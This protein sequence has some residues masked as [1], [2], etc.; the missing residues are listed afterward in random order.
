MF[1][2]KMENISFRRDEYGYYFIDRCGHIFQHILQFLRCGKL[3]LP[4]SF[5]ELELLQLEADF[6]QIGDLASAI[7]YHKREVE[8]NQRD[9]VHT[10]LLCIVQYHQNNK[11]NN[12]IKLFKKSKDNGHFKFRDHDL[13]E[14]R[15][16]KVV[17]AY[18]QS[19]SWLLKEHETT[20]ENVA[21]VFFSMRDILTTVIF[22]RGK[23]VTYTSVDVETW[24]RNPDVGF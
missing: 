2:E 6:Y 4:D 20:E 7:D 5:N 8:V 12:Y 1:M 10:L 13:I 16:E 11:L 9:D 15:D 18:L 24:I 14:Y 19:D 17:R 23:N 22:N 21:C 3:V